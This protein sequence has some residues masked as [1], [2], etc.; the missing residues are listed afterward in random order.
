MFYYRHTLLQDYFHLML[1]NKFLLFV[2][3]HIL[4]HTNFVLQLANKH[5]KHIS[6][7]YSLKYFNAF[8]CQTTAAILS[9][10]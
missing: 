2:F 8:P 5:N 6:S 1:P 10:L 3:L 7:V 9:G 4:M